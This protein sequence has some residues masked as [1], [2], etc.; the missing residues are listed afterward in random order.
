V[1]RLAKLSGVDAL[2]AEDAGLFMGSVTLEADL[3][4]TSKANA[5]AMAAAA[6]SFAATSS[7]RDDTK[8]KLL[9]GDGTAFVKGMGIAKG[10]FAQR[11]AALSPTLDTPP[12]IE[13][14]LRW[15][16]K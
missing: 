9:A 2:A 6:A 4:D 11:L 7:K 13:R 3:F 16:E 8:E 10:R 14:A 1:A 15:L 12:Y 5:T